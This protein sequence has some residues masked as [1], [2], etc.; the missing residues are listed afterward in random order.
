LTTWFCFG[1][2]ARMKV[3]VADRTTCS[4]AKMCEVT[5]AKV[6]NKKEDPKFSAIQ[7]TQDATGKPV[8]T[9]CDQCGECIAVCPTGALRRANSGVVLLKKDL[10]VACYM[11]IGFCPTNAMFRAEGQLE[12]FKCISCGNCVK[13]CPCGTLQMVEKDHSQLPR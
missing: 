3:L 11:C 10:C 6:V 7:V 5:C 13:T 2:I 12:P 4:I 8:L 1:I 9:F